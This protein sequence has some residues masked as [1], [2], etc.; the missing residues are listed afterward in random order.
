MPTFPTLLALIA[1]ALSLI[2]ARPGPPPAHLIPLRELVIR[3]AGPDQSAPPRP[4]PWPVLDQAAAIYDATIAEVRQ[5]FARPGE[6]PI[7]VTATPDVLL[8][9]P[10]PAGADRAE[11]DA[12]LLALSLLEQ[13][14]FF[15]LCARLPDMGVGVCLDVDPRTGQLGCQ[16]LAPISAMSRALAV[17]MI[18][19][20]ASGDAP[21]AVALFEQQA[22]MARIGAHQVS[23]MASVMRTRVL[24]AAIR[25]LSADLVLGD[26]PPAQA[27][28]L[29]DAL[30]RQSARPG[31]ALTLEAERFRLEALIARTHTLTPDNDGRLLITA[32]HQAMHD[33]ELFVAFGDEPDLG[34]L[35]LPDLGPVV[36]VLGVRFSSRSRTLALASD[37]A[38]RLSALA[39]LPYDRHSNA[40]ADVRQWAS[41]LP[42]PDWFIRF[43]VDSTILAVPMLIRRELDDA[44]RL[45]GLILMLAI[46]SH[47]A[48][49]GRLP[50]TLDDLVPK[51]LPALPTDPYT[52][53]PF[54]YRVT[55]PAPEAPGDGYTLYSLWTD[56][57]DNNGQRTSSPTQHNAIPQRRTNCDYIIN[58]PRDAQATR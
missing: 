43:T 53:R 42:K 57:I 2:T 16:R 1:E 47:R 13:R 24:G 39:D 35:D 52:G 34:P 32:V 48:A 7:F 22:A 17:R 3:H 58:D 45:R 6:D 46:E 36:N 29:L 25:E 15:D 19:A 11:R 10:D 33:G 21:A 9:E 30:N 40:I 44:V 51:T 4:D 55:N 37:Y 18:L 26:I 23:T 54:V 28:P 38:T 5:R 14:G 50:A 41:S 12:A 56:G 31:I 27:R 20:R 49:T 8:R